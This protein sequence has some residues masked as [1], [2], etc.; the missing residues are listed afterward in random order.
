[1]VRNISGVNGVNGLGEVVFYVHVNKNV[2]VI[3]VRRLTFG[4]W[5]QIV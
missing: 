2:N 1:M 5:L 4:K 3:I